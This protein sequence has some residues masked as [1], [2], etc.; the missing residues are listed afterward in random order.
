MIIKARSLKSRCWFLPKALEKNPSLPLRGFWWLLTILDIP[1]F[2]LLW[3]HS[4]LCL[5][6]YVTSNLGVFVSESFSLCCVRMPVIGCRAQF[7]LVLTYLIMSAKTFFPNKVT[8]C[9]F[10]W[11]RSFEGHQL[12]KILSTT[13]TEILIFVC[14]MTYAPKFIVLSNPGITCGRL[15]STELL[16]CLCWEWGVHMC[17]GLFLDSLFCSIDIFVYLYTNV[18][19][20]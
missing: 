5:H 8:F 1:G 20:S 14:D 16:L 12:I 17:V 6:H 13:M 11:T 9:G 2:G 19:L 10:R 15:S 4:S 18:T 3:H 7:D